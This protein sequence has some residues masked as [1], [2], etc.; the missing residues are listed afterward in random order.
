MITSPSFAMLIHDLVQTHHEGN[1]RAMSQKSGLPYMTLSRWEHG[2]AESPRIDRILQLCR[3][4]GLD[5]GEVL[6][7]IARDAQT[8]ARGARPLVA[9]ISRTRGPAP[10]PHSRRSRKRFGKKLIAILTT[11]AAAAFAPPTYA[12]VA[13]TATLSVESPHRDDC[14]GNASYR[15]RRRRGLWPD[16]HDRRRRRR[17][18]DRRRAIAISAT[19]GAA[20]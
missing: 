13:P 19:I 12:A 8:R 11:A 3:Y 18:Y 17:G 2:E 10:D 1:L 15:R 9:E 7:V 5:V 6:G 4:Y 20:A 14:L 16:P